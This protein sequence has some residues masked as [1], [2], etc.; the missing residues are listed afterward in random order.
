M[1]ELWRKLWQVVKMID[2][3]DVSKT[4]Q[5]FRFFMAPGVGHCAMDTDP[6]FE[7]LVKWVETGEAPETILH[8]VSANTTRPLCLHPEVAIYSGSGSTGDPANFACG[9]NPVGPDTEDCDARVNQRL[10][11]EP[12]VPSAPCPGC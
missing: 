10:F 9:P 1:T 4:Q 12:F 11:G 6:Y 5:W 8:Q 3:G 2:G 7:A